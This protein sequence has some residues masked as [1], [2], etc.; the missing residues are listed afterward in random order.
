MRVSKL[1]LDWSLQHGK[2]KFEGQVQ[3]LSL[4]DISSSEI[5]LQSTFK[6]TIKNTS[7]LQLS[8]TVIVNLP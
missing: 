3:D 8:M 1:Y 2:K 4:N 6:E 7:I 5:K